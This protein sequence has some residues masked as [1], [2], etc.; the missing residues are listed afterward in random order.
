MMLAMRILMRKQQDGLE[1]GL[2]QE[3]ANMLVLGND[4][5]DPGSMGPL[6][7]WMPESVWPKIKGLEALK[8]FKGLG[9]IMQ[10]DYDDWEHW[11]ELEYPDLE[12]CPGDFATSLSSFDRLILLR[13]MRPDRVQAALAVYVEETMG[14]AYVN[15]PAFDMIATF[16]E[17]NPQTPVFFVLFPGV[18]PTVWVEG[19]GNKLGFTMANGKFVMISMGQGQEKPAESCM[20][21]FGAEGGWILLQNCH[22]MEKWLP[23][24]ERKFETT[25]DGAHKD[26]KLMLSAEAPGLSYQK[27]MPESLMQVSIKV[28]NEAPADIKSNLRRSWAEFDEHT[29]ERCSKPNEF[30]G[31]LFMLCWFHSVVQGRR[32]F[33]QQGWSRQ[34][35]FNTGDLKICADVLGQYL[36]ASPD[37]PYTDLQYVWGEI[38]YGGHVTD[39]WD[40]RTSSFYLEVLLNEGIFKNYEF[41][42][43]CGFRSPNP[44][45]FQFNDYAQY[46]ETALPVESPPLFGLHMNA[47]LAYLVN[48][49][50]AVFSNIMA[51]MGGGGGDGGGDDGGGSAGVMANLLERMPD[52]FELIGIG[53]MA[54]PL[55]E[56][57][58]EGPFVVVCMQECKRMNYLLT[59]IKGTLQDLEKGFAGL[60]NMSQK[61]EDLSEALGKNQTPG[62]NPFHTCNWE[63]Y[64]WPSVKF[65]APWWGNLV[66]RCG[67][68][69]NWSA[70]LARPLV[71]WFSGLFNSIA[72]IT[73]LMQVTARSESLP[74]DKMTTE[75]HCTL[76]WDIDEA[77]HNPKDG[78]LVYG[79]FMEGARWPAKAEV[80]EP[81]DLDG[82]MTGGNI[83]EM[84]LKEVL[85]TMPLIYIKSI[86]LQAHWEPQ[87][88][89]L[90]GKGSG[91]VA[92]F[93]HDIHSY[94]SPTY[95][96]TF[97]GPT[98]CMLATLH[99]AHGQAKWV[100]AGVALICQSDD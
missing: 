35:P 96:T 89:A 52:F 2:A 87:S 61:M 75:T 15:Q 94:E 91:A 71:S 7:E 47:E 36:D 68:L 28:A 93:R 60:L 69:T 19:A 8:Q 32:R 9:D 72:L 51:M 25:S 70:D 53:I 22:L 45:D 64:A 77:D 10:T 73:A 44:A 99:T 26:Y 31:C 56:I 86:E 29:I 100:L 30:K 38:M 46:I 13:M 6:S 82:T 57:E 50:V 40:R 27:N 21:R 58:A 84:K 81:V 66:A 79:L 5:L 18:D 42:E 83:V 11:F 33:G 55:L 16:E 88:I 90:G 23:A 62:R 4:V 20:E 59:E 12:P 63:F 76:M 49:Q 37:V 34:Y 1:G 54:K 92:F 48:F 14:S 3:V 97:R 95:T 80:E 67:F 43:G 98:Y 39:A 78:Q 17:T 85:P 41:A 65:L 24:L 74:L